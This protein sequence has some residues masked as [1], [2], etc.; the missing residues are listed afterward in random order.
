MENNKEKSNL[1]LDETIV[2]TTHKLESFYEKFKKQI[3]LGL[4]AVAAV[5]AGYMGFKMWYLEP[6]EQEAQAAIFKAQQ[7]FEQDSFALALNGAG[8]T[9][10][11]EAIASEFGLTKAGNLAHYYAGICNMKLG[12]FD[13]AVDHLKSFSTDNALLAPLSEGLK[14]DAYSELGDYGKAAKQYLKAAGL[15]K[16]KLTAPIYLK[17]AGLVLEEQKEFND[18]VSAYEKIKKDYS[19]SQEAQDIDKYIA[20]AKTLA[21]NS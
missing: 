10:G 20:R 13:A 1:D 5:I 19:D 17:K 21:Q 3:N 12:N 2:E 8:E 15:T 7:W 9:Q 4:I 14:G 16:N 11:F 6:K 18:A